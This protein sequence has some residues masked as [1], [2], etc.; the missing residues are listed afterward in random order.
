MAKVQF[1]PTSHL[2][3]EW[4]TVTSVHR[5]EKREKS[6]ET[7]LLRSFCP[8]LLLKCSFSP[9]IDAHFLSLS[10]NY[11]SIVHTHTH[12]RPAREKK[13]FVTEWSCAQRAHRTPNDKKMKWKKKRIEKSS[14]GSRFNAYAHL[15][16]DCIFYYYIYNM[17]IIADSLCSLARSSLVCSLSRRMH[18]FCCCTF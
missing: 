13:E 12:T 6:I 17:I 16:A 14:A 8:F 1:V 4:K 2:S 9:F 18:F 3:K 10:C 5:R 15:P 11:S 7:C